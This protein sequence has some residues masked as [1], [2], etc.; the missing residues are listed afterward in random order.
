MTGG[1]SSEGRVGGAKRD[2]LARLHYASP[3][4]I[5]IQITMS[6][7][8]MIMYAAVIESKINA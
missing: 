1:H 7:I 4:A 6:C 2:N 8:V 3:P 5:I